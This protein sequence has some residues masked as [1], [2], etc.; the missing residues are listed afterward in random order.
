MASETALVTGASSGIGRELARLLAADGANLVLVARR[1]DK[2]D[3]LA[4]E[5]RQQFG[6]QV[7]TLAFDLS[8]P[9]APQ[10]LC[11]KLAEQGTTVDVLVNNAG[12]GARGKLVEI[13]LEK[14]L[15]MVRLNVVCLLELTR[16]LLPGMMERRRG[17]VLNVASTAAFQ[18]GPNMAVYFATKAFVL[19]L[20][21]ALFEETRGTGVTVTC[22]A[23]G[24]TATEFAKVAQMEDARLFSLG[25]LPAETVAKAGYRGFRQGKALVVPGLGNKLVAFGVRFTP[26][27]LV[28]K[29][30]ARL[31][32]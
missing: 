3:E 23:P 31:P 6:V 17:G 30:A 11:D 7:Q 21:E 25:M 32:E 4:A 13:E 10:Q 20:S 22:L 9:A 2:L 29:I 1:V 14:Q 5:V 24:P 18:P 15:E 28:R 19:S 27:W 26:R 12:F 16:R 8:D